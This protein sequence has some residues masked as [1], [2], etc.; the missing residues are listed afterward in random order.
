MV[1]PTC[2]VSDVSALAGAWRAVSI[3]YPR[4][5]AH[6]LKSVGGPQSAL[7]GRKDLMSVTAV[8][9]SGQLSRMVLS[10]ASFILSRLVRSDVE[11][12]LELGGELRQLRDANRLRASTR[13]VRRAVSPDC[14]QDPRQFS[15]QRYDSDALASSLLDL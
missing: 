10:A 8:T 5:V 3:E 12:E 7:R 6:R 9:T 11:L 4:S 15:R 14:V 13:I 2:F 1:F